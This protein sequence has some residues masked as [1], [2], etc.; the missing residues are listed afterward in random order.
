MARPAPALRNGGSVHAAAVVWH[1]QPALLTPHDIEKTGSAS[2]FV[3]ALKPCGYELYDVLVSTLD[4][5]PSAA[6][7]S[8]LK[9]T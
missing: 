2:G 1:H 4:Y 3:M 8:L 6:N 5:V 9:P 7:F